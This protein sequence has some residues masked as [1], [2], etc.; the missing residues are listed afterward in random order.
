MQ[1]YRRCVNG[2]GTQMWVNVDAQGCERL[3]VQLVQYRKVRG[4]AC[5]LQALPWT[6]A[7]ASFPRHKHRDWMAKVRRACKGHAC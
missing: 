7:A 3:C 4:S 6:T 5:A 1:A 2:G